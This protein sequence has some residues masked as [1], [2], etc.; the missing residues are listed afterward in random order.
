MIEPG[1]I[2]YHDNKVAFK[3]RETFFSECMTNDY[4]LGWKDSQWQD[5]VFLY[6]ENMSQ[7]CVDLFHSYAYDIYEE[8]LDGY[9]PVRMVTNC[10][11]PGENSFPHLDIPLAAE[12]EKT[13]DKAISVLYFP[14]PIWER[15]WGGETRFYDSYT[16]EVIFA[17]NYTPGRFL[18]FD[19]ELQHCNGIQSYH[20]T[21]FRFTIVSQYL[22]KGYL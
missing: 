14:N 12:Q 17:C 8:E 16:D 15:K 11:L 7:K 1:T 20:A 6:C 9:E 4:K 2:L 5:D 19:S 22:P 13:G 21:H 3:D 10:C 18:L